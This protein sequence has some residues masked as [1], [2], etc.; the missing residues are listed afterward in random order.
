MIHLLEKEDIIANEELNGNIQTL[1][2]YG[3]DFVSMI[4]LIIE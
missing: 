3:D 4:P 2:D 1:D